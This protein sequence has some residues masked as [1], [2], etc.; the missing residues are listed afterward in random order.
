MRE[1]GR[2]QR[3]GVINWSLLSG[4]GSSGPW[5]KGEAEEEEK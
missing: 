3:E 4:A 2:K 5:E 1:N